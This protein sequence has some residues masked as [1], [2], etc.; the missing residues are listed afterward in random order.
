MASSE[1]ASGRLAA[2]PAFQADD[3]IAM[4]R[5]PNRHRRCSLTVYFGYRFA[6]PRECVMNGAR[7]SDLDP[8]ELESVEPARGIGRNWN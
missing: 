7:R 6:K 2:P 1:M 5:S 3:V 4:N 8:S